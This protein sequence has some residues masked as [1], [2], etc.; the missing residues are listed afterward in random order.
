MRGQTFAR[1]FFCNYYF[2]S[3][4][5]NFYFRLITHVFSVTKTPRFR[6]Q[7]LKQSA[8]AKSSWRQRVREWEIEKKLKEK[9]C[10][11]AIRMRWMCAKRPSILPS[12]GRVK[13][14][15]SPLNVV[16]A[17][18][19]S[20]HHENSIRCPL[21]KQLIQSMIRKCAKWKEK[22]IRCASRDW[23]RS[24]WTY[25]D[26]RVHSHSITGETARS[27]HISIGCGCARCTVDLK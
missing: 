22:W 2:G 25:V 17:S 15:F 26:R 11:S 6:V 7:S 10:V 18:M 9:N 3:P 4:H 1:I 20:T 24:G 13:Y 5:S 16:S 21:Y 8:T 19:F 27:T 12:I 14:L 23:M